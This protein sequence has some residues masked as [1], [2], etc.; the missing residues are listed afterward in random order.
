MVID[1]KDTF[2]LITLYAKRVNKEVHVF[3]KEGKLKAKYPPTRYRPTKATKEITL[4][5]FVWAL[6]WL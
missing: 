1:K 6:V 4:N 3:T 2:K 5:C